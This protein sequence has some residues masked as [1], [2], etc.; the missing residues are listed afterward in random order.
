MK[1]GVHIMILIVG[2][3]KM[4][5]TRVNT[6]VNQHGIKNL[7]TPQFLSEKMSRHLSSLAPGFEG[8]WIYVNTG[9]EATIMCRAVYQESIDNKIH[10]LVEICPAW[11]VEDVLRNITQ[12]IKKHPLSSGEE[13][14]AKLSKFYTEIMVSFLYHPD[15]AYQKI[16]E[17]L[18]T[19]LK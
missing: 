6:M 8:H 3:A 17:Y 11:Q 7:M 2:T 9:F 10:P 18:W 15:T 4:Q 16:E 14:V 19:V 1:H 13:Y 5:N 12:I